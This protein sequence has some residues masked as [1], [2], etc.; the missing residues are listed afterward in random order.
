MCPEGKLII[1]ILQPGSQKR[2]VDHDETRGGKE[3]LDHIV[4]G[5]GEAAEDLVGSHKDRL[6]FRELSIF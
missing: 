4:V 2:S 3:N 5:L 1:W 6:Q